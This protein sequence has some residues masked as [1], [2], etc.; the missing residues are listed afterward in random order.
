MYSR[1]TDS[2]CPG[3]AA[4]ICSRCCSS[5]PS[6]M[7]S[8]IVHLSYKSI[9]TRISLSVCAAYAVYDP[10]SSLCSACVSWLR[11]STC[12]HVSCIY[13]MPLNSC[14]AFRS[15]ESAP[16]TSRSGC[17]MLSGPAYKQTTYRINIERNYLLCVGNRVGYF[18]RM[19]YVSAFKLLHDS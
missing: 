2:T 4:L 14:Y 3:Q 8:G 19:R 17:I 1:G 9:I 5:C 6:I 16:C 12:M 10:P 15:Q 18:P 7:S 11:Y 13:G